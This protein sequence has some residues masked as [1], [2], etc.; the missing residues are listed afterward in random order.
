M[1][2]HSAVNE[3]KTE[4]FCKTPSKRDE[5]F[6]DILKKLRKKPLYDSTLV[7]LKG[8]LKIFKTLICISL[9]SQFY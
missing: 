1:V 5:Q 7:N 9:F 3:W 6:W 8:T 4:M 2:V